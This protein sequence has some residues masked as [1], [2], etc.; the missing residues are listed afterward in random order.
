MLLKF[1]SLYGT[2][3]SGEA[4]MQRFY[5]EKQ[6]K[7]E[8]CVEWS[9]CL[10]DYIYEAMELGIV[11]PDSAQKSLASRF[12]SGLYEDRVKN[13]LRHR[14]D[15]LDFVELVMEARRIEEEYGLNHVAEDGAS[16]KV[17][18]SQVTAP[19]SSVSEDKLD[20]I[21]KRLSQL[22]SQVS[23]MKV[24]QAAGSGP[25]P[26]Q[27]QYRQWS[28]QAEPPRVQEPHGNQ[29]RRDRSGMKCIKCQIPGHLAF[30]CRQGSDVT[31]YKCGYTGHI[32]AACLN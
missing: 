18:S 1:Q 15:S 27:P 23:D 11:S 12:W 22:E 21:I 5:G 16:Q 13:A 4:L 20:L 3:L 26:P 6:G 32:Q 8:T 7:G 30:G 29:V 24:N 19:K 17:K 31:C 14:E 2:V 25:P 10:E 9:C 28:A